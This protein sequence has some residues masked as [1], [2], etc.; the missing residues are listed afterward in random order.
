MIFKMNIHPAMSD[1]YRSYTDCYKVVEKKNNNAD[2]VLVL[3]S[4]IGA[5]VVCMWCQFSN[6]D[7]PPEQLC[8]LLLWVVAIIASF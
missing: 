5:G 3:N 1:Y 8:S 2:H 6:N 7:I 4:H